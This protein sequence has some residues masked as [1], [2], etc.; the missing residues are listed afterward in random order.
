MKLYL[1][2]AIIL[3]VTKKSSGVVISSL[4]VTVCRTSR[5]LFAELDDGPRFPGKKSVASHLSV[6]LVPSERVA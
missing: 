2:N 6:C 5:G 4:V 1:S 3:V